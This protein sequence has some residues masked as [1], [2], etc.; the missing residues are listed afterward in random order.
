MADALPQQQPQVNVVVDQLGTE[1]Q[2]VF[3]DFL[4]TF[5]S[6]TDDQLNNGDNDDDNNNNNNRIYKYRAMLQSMKDMD[7]INTTFFIDLQDVKDFH[8]DLYQ[9]IC[10]DY[11]RLL[12]FLHEAA[13]E[14]GNSNRDNNNNVNIHQQQK[15]YWISF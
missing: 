8:V 14:F 12:P 6:E 3:Y 7:P 13:T 5:Q 10:K 4:D 15:D 11:F 9:Q 1:V 2:R